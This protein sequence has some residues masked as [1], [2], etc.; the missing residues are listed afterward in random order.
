MKILGV[1]VGAILIALGIF[2]LY[3]WLIMVLWNFL[4]PA[5]IQ[6]GTTITFWQG[7]ALYF[8]T[9]ILVGRFGVAK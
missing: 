9:S 8:L 4:V 1:L 2:A 5:L 3:G 6:G 7:L